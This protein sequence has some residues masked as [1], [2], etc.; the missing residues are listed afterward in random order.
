MFHKDLTE[1][2]L[3]RLVSEGASFSM[4]YNYMY[5]QTGVDHASIYTGMMPA[6]HGIV[7][8]AWYDR[9]RGKRQYSTS[10]ENRVELGELQVDSLPSLS[11]AALQ[12]LSLGSFMKLHNP[13][14]KV[15]SIAMNGN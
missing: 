4:N 7:G 8:T 3:K 2:G 11:P 10:S 1:G 13:L 6:D 9:L 12:A 14:S 5:T 15:Y